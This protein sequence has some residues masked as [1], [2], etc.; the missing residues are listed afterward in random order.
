LCSAYFVVVTAKGAPAVA[1]TV[2]AGL[3]AA[4]I[5]VCA[6]AFDATAA[7]T[8]A[9]SGSIGTLILLVIYLLTTVGSIMPVSVRRKR[10]GSSYFHPVHWL[11]SAIP[12][13]S[14]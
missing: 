6:V 4:I 10:A 7:D 13:T 11:C 3:A 14:T 8:F 12:S 2:V 5:V 1:A 9:W